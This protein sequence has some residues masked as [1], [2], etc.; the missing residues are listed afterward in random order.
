VISLLLLSREPGSA[1][2]ALTIPGGKRFT[3]KKRKSAKKLWEAKNA[4]AKLKSL[5]GLR[6][7][8]VKKFRNR[9]SL[10]REYNPLTPT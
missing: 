1:S 3:A 10:E 8:A 7:F 6:V 5:R 9:V 2:L 4:F